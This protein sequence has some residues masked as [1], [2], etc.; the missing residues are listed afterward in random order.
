MYQALRN[1]GQYTHEEITDL[2]KIETGLKSRSV[3]FDPVSIRARHS[4]LQSCWIVE[5]GSH[6]ETPYIKH[7]FKINGDIITVRLLKDVHEME[8]QEY[9]FKKEEQ[10]RQK[11]SVTEKSRR[12]RT[13]KTKNK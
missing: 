5:F 3:Q 4:S 8:F 10:R 13:R 2:L 12:H 11:E 7:W 6:D 9:K 1:N